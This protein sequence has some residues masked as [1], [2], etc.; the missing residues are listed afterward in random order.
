MTITGPGPVIQA[1]DEPQARRSTFGTVSMTTKPGDQ[2][3]ARGRPARRRQGDGPR[4][5]RGHSDDA[6]REAFRGNTN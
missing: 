3:P 4:S 1:A 2:G 6:S 5:V